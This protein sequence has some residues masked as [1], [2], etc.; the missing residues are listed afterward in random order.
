MGK[1]PYEFIE[2]T[3]D[4]GIRVRGGSLEDL[5][6]NAALAMFEIIAERK[7]SA[8]QSAKK[9]LKIKQTADTTDELFINWLSELLS[10]SSAKGLIFS[11]LKIEKMD[12]TGLRATAAGEDSG[13]YRFNREIKAVTYHGFKLEQGPSGWQAEVIFDV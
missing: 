4:I 9:H 6:K 11:D 10:L 7:K 12:E 8:P 2:H 13:N 3:A 5:F 1:I